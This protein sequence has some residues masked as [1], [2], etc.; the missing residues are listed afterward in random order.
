MTTIFEVME[1]AGEAKCFSDLVEDC[2]AAEESFGQFLDGCAREQGRIFVHTSNC[3]AA[4]V[5]IG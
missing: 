4:V 2:V 5:G 1:S 3:N